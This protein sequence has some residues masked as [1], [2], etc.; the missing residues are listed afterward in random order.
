[1]S[2]DPWH[3]LVGVLA[4]SV[5]V[6]AAVVVGMLRQLGTLL[7]QLQPPRPGVL[8]GQGPTP[9]L[10]IP[11]SEPA[12]DAAGVVVF[13]SPSCQLC[14]AVADVLPTLERR[15]PEL[16][17]R[18]LV[19]GDDEALVNQYAR[20]VRAGGAVADSSS[21]YEQW[22]VPGTPFAVGVG[23]D[24]RV[25]VSGVVNALAQLETLADTVVAAT[26]VSETGSATDESERE[27]AVGVVR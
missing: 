8:E 3:L 4:L 27:E 24:R 11:D 6:L 13:L 22:Q 25:V 20:T 23:S 26:R 16:R 14:P 17:V 21:L 19:V 12:G 1:M 18:A 7:I 5:V 2:V 15:Y 10:A 9:G